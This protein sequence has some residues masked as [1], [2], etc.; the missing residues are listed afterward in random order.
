MEKLVVLTLVKDDVYSKSTPH[1]LENHLD[2][3]KAGVLKFAEI[4]KADKIMVLLPKGM[5]NPG[6]DWPVKE[7]ILTPT[8]DN[9]YSVQQQFLGNLPR[10]MIQD[11]FAAVYEGLEIATILP[12]NAYWLGKN[13]FKYT[14]FIKAN[15]IFTPNFM[16]GIVF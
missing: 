7:G 11:D 15:I 14:S 13:G 4:N 16:S 6:F 3:V 5:T 2:D 8:A 10:P 12:E 1:F 9:P